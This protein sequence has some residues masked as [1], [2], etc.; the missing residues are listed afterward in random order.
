MIPQVQQKQPSELIPCIMDFVR[1]LPS[2]ETIS[3]VDVK[4]YDDAGVDCSST[5][6]DGTPTVI[7]TQVLARIIGGT[8]GFRGKITYLVTTTPS[9]YILEEDVLLEV[10]ER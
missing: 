4:V 1:V 2:G 7:G 5:M 6:L 9:G 10:D 3:T 8:S